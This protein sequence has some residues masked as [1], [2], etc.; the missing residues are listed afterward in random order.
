MPEDT[1]TLTKDKD[2]LC[3]IIDRHIEREESN[4]SYRY[5]MWSLAWYYLN[6][7]RRFDVF[8][9]ESGLLQPHHL[10]EDGNMEF[11]SQELLSAIDR[12][13]GVLSAMDV[14]PKIL[15]SGSSLS[16]IRDRSIAQVIADAMVSRDRADETLTEFAYLLASCGSAGIAG[17]VVDHP[18]VGLSSDLEV[19]H[20]R[21]L[22]PFPSLGMDHTKQR[23]LIRERI[24]PMDYLVEKFGRRIKTNMEKLY[25]FD[26]EAGQT[27]HDNE[28]YAD[29][30]NNIG[31]SPRYNSSYAMPGGGAS[32]DETK[33]SLVRIR[34]LWLTGHRNTVTRYVV[35]SGDYVIVDE[36][37]SDV[38]VYCPIGVARF[39]ET[40][41]FYGAGL[42]DLLFSISREMEKLLKA[43]FNNIRDMDQYGILVLPQ[44]Q[45]NERAALRDVGRGLRVL[46]YEPDAIDPGFRPFN[47][48][49]MTTGDLPGKTA[50]YAKSLMDQINPFR[51]LVAN[52][53]R[54]D[55]AAGLGFLDEKN[56]QLM[57]TPMRSI[58]KAFSQSHRAML[59]QAS[60]ALALS[61]RAVPVNNLTLDLAGAII[62]PE[63]SFVSFAQN[64]LPSVSNL[65]ITI[66]ETNPRSEVARKQ[67]AL[68]LFAA[69]GFNDPMRFMLL[70]LQ[71]GLDFAVYMEEERAAYEMV[72]K[73][74]LILYSNGEA[75]GEIIVTPHTALPN[76]QLRVLT[77]FMAGP[78]MAMA[79]PEVQDEFMKYKQ[80]LQQGLGNI[81][82]EGVPP[83]E[84]A[85]M[86]RM[87]QQGRPIPQPQRPQPQRPSPAGVR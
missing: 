67:E 56:R 61:R 33:Y 75:P 82:P 38:E 54:V 26:V 18:T 9:P 52:K 34:E 39:I 46:P 32:T 55:S 25:Y 74:C 71:E 27:P 30:L 36:D 31:T 72:V 77:S 48:A 19:I 47:I 85:A 4:Y 81:L 51:D 5:T 58:E 43:L 41:S 49:P 20:P 68:Q 66:K 24:V 79:S 80:F 29:R 35:T 45:F 53:G 1:Y 12:V 62:D 44:G 3:R 65:G 63:S 42:F 60:R 78:Q 28:D 83:P 64:P 70:S 15:R 23:G 21:E 6:G 57:S 40:G 7:A 11:Q 8:D 84:Q 10:D 76:L 86:Q 14:R 13:V 73:N 16:Q 17:H 59:A 87:Q 50:Q 22:Y 37:Y 2:A 69:P